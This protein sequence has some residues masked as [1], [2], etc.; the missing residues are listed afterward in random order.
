MDIIQGSYC[1]W[2]PSLIT[3]CWL[4]DHM[5]CG[6]LD[7]TLPSLMQNGDTRVVVKMVSHLVQ[8][9]YQSVYC[10]CKIPVLQEVLEIQKMEVDPT[11]ILFRDR[12]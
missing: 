5:E 10:V 4:P 1:I 12:A 11:I 6:R 8:L 9:Q 3:S 2:P 7:P